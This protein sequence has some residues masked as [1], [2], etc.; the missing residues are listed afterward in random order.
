N[1]TSEKPIKETV[2]FAASNIG[3]ELSFNTIKN[4]TGLTSATTIKEYFEYLENSYLVFLIPKYDPSLKKQAYASKK[5]YFVDNGMANEIGF[6][7]SE[8]EGRLLENVVFL[9]L[10]RFGKDIFFH[11]NKKE[12]D[13]LIREGLKIKQAI[14]VTCYLNDKNKER[15]IDGLMEALDKYKLKEGLILTLDEEKEINK[16]NKKIIIMPVWK[17]LLEARV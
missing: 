6:R 9:E 10:K 16:N 11:R 15:E 14:Q 13:F 12:C 4:I 17:W 2:Y 3:K 5:A 8:D 7:V 1:L